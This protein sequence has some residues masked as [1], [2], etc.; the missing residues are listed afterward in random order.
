MG[1][2][3]TTTKSYQIP[4]MPIRMTLA[5]LVVQSYNHFFLVEQPSQSLLY[6]HKRFQWL[7]NR[8]SWDP[9]F[10]LI[11]YL[12]TQFC[13]LFIISKFMWFASP[14]CTLWGAGCS[15]TEELPV[16][17]QFFGGNLSTMGDLNR[18]RLTQAERVAKTTVSTTRSLVASMDVKI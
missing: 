4:V 1:C 8:V 17:P 7:T 13:W 12:Q 18:G 6:M 14:R 5:I 10:K 9:W 11:G 2:M 15:T 16:N 3:F